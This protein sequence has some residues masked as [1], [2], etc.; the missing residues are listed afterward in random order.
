MG[1]LGPNQKYIVQYRAKQKLFKESFGQ[2]DILPS[3]NPNDPVF[4]YD[5]T[6]QILDNIDI[7]LGNIVTEEHTLDEIDKL[8]SSHPKHLR[9][10][11][12]MYFYD[13]KT[14][15]EIADYY[16]IHRVT[17]SRQLNKLLKHVKH[18]L[19]TDPKFRSLGRSH[20][21]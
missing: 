3:I 9:D 8:V 15:F 11:F 14:T 16:K 2:P 4:K 10:V 1:F 19:S 5:P 18:V 20:R 21:S 6:D 17:V 13:K 7:S 12:N